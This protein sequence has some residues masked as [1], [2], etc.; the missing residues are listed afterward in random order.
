M[1]GG[2]S[3]AGAGLADVMSVIAWLPGLV[4]LSFMGEAHALGY[5]YRNNRM[6]F[7]TKGD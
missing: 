3:L 5:V 4:W 2:S 7:S 6:P 1:V